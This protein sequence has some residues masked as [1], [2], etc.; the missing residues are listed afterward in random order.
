[1]KTGSLE[2]NNK[3]DVLITNYYPKTPI[4]HENVMGHIMFGVLNSTID[5]TIIDGTIRMK[6]GIIKNIDLAE[7]AEQSTLHAQE[8]WN[9]IT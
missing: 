6:E 7:I 3:A 5:T 8:V 4:S 1:M 2:V 9:R